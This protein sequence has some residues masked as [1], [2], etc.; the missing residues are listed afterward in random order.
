MCV[1]E[2]D[3]SIYPTYNFIVCVDLFVQGVS[4]SLLFMYVKSEG[5]IDMTR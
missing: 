1:C 5:D 3:R 4:V 2:V